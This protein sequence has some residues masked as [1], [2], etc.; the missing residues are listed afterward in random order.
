MDLV[1]YLDDLKELERKDR[2]V[3]NLD[4]L[5]RYIRLPPP[6]KADKLAPY[7]DQRWDRPDRD[8]IEPDVI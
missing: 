8:S 5:Q 4:L 6:L 1:S 7:R 3:T 2:V